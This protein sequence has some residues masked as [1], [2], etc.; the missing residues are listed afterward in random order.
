MCALFRRIS[1][2]AKAWWVAAAFMV[3]LVV[4]LQFIWAGA[5]A[6]IAFAGLER[7]GVDYARPLLDLLQAAQGRRLAAV[8]AG[9]DLPEWQTRVQAAFERVQARDAELG[10]RFGADKPFAA[11]RQ[12]HQAL[13]AAPTAGS[14]DETQLAH[15]RYVAAALALLGEV[16]NGS[17][18][19]LDPDA[20]TF[21]M[22]E[23]SV[24]RGPLQLE[25]TARLLSLGVV[26]L[27]SRDLSAARREQMTRWSAVSDLIERDVENAYQRGIDADPALEAVF[28][29]K[30]TDAAALA[31]EDSVRTQVLGAEPT[32]SAEAFQALG[33]AALRRQTDLVHKVLDRLDAGLQQRIDRVRTTLAAQLGASLLCILAAGYLMVSFYKV[34]TGGLQEVA[35]HLSEI[36]R[37]NLTT[38]PVPWGRDEAAH[39]ML[40]LG[41]MQASLRRVVGCVLEASAQVQAASGRNLRGHARPVA[42][43]R[44][45][46]RQP[47]RNGRQHRADC[48]HRAA[49]GRDGGRRNGHRARQRRSGHARW[50]GHRPGGAD[51]GGHQQLVQQDRRRSSL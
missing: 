50:R 18:L 1:F 45:V 17:Q 6:Q 13:L 35:S 3:P 12:A 11:L 14:A 43:H 5:A 8:A 21:H 48:R 27:K 39:L 22:M 28:D 37:G 38:A 32:G 36:S 2:Q 40:A 25:N 16:A 31:F 23:L 42:P 47:G 44:A 49:D 20:D 34:M 24:A 10:R 9:A 46:G 26:V 19:V 41:E 29:M 51:H 30:G 33:Q 7:Q 15:D 4:L